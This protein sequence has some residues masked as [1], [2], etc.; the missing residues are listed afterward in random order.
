MGPDFVHGIYSGYLR[1]PD[2]GSII[3]GAHGMDCRILT[4]RCE[5]PSRQHPKCTSI[6]RLVVSLDG[7]WGILTLA[8]GGCLHGAV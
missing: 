5:A 3:L 4:W 1:I 8:V 2:Q 7:I 6:K